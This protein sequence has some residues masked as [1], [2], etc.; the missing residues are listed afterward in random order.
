MRTE[1]RAPEGYVCLAAIYSKWIALLHVRRHSTKDERYTTNLV[2]N[3][4][5]IMLPIDLFIVLSSFAVLCRCKYRNGFITSKF[6]TLCHST[7]MFLQ[8]VLWFDVLCCC[9]NV[10]TCERAN[11][12]HWKCLACML[13]VGGWKWTEICFDGI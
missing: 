2:Y 13:H 5:S 8:N 7:W 3:L 6:R 11:C 12:L 1:H 4:P 9:L 10:R